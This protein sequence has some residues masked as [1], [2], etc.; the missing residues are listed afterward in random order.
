METKYYEYP[1]PVDNKG[2]GI[3][4]R[5]QNELYENELL[6]LQQAELM[7]YA[8]FEAWT[9]LGTNTQL[10]YSTHGIFRYFG[11]FPAT[12]A[13]HL[14]MEYTDEH[15]MVMDP[16]AGSGT[17]AVE[18]MLANRDCRSY[19]VN[20]LS[21]LL[22]KVKTTHISKQILL[23]ALDAIISRYTPMTLEQYDYCP[24]GIKDIDHWFLPKTQD[25]IRGI[26]YQ[27]QSIPDP[28]VRDF[29]EI[30]LAASIRTVSRATTQQGRLFLDVVTAR[31]DCLETFVK[32]SRKAIDAVDGIPD[33]QSQIVIEERDA[34]TP[35]DH[36]CVNR[37]IIVHPPYFNSYKYSSVNSLELSWMRINHADVRKSEVREF[38][39]VGK[40][41]KVEFYVEDMAHALNNIASTLMVEGRMGLM[42][43]DTIIKG[44]YIKTTKMT[45]DRFLADHPSFSIEKIVLRVPKY[46]EASWTASQRREKDKVGISL[47]DFIVVFRRDA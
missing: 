18:A 35:F 34:T 13:T 21:V 16:M 26:Q 36:D 3:E 27:I 5:K 31:E 33:T 17:T 12:I 7:G 4:I 32:K 46:T 25:S 9:A 8:P 41:E 43:G 44:Q 47:N 42:I 40:P 24:V 2:A 15:D 6:L 37:L 30:C 29:F 22:A 1:N 39:K 38:F 14:I 45:I 28:N 19:D 20:P 11:K 10:S 23:P